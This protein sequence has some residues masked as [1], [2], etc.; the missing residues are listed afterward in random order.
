MLP[1]PVSIVTA[2]LSIAGSAYKI[3]KDTYDLIQGIRGAPSHITR[4]SK[5][6]QGLYGVLGTLH[7]LA[8][9]AKK[10]VKGGLINTLIVDL[11][12]LLRNCVEVFRDIQKI[13]VPF[14][15]DGSKHTAWKGFKWEMFKKTDVTGLQSTL[16]SYK[17]SL[18]IACQAL[19]MCVCVCVCSQRLKERVTWG[20]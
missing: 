19:L 20:S 12:D 18:S 8:T 11:E 9:E 16:S 4:L 7:L 10:K 5:D 17:L 3:S 15:S 1:E 14:E 13:L 6:I 2:A